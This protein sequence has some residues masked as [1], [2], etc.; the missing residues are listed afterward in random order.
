L[1][2]RDD[3]GVGVAL[4]DEE[5]RENGPVGTFCR[6]RA[7]SGPVAR[8][9]EKSESGPSAEMSEAKMAGSARQRLAMPSNEPRAVTLSPTFTSG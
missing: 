3:E 5:G 4:G 7:S 9:V 2:V 1:H 8:F 6:K